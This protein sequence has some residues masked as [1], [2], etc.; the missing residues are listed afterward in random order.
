MFEK[1]VEIKHDTDLETG[2]ITCG[3]G[4]GLDRMGCLFKLSKTIV[5]SRHHEYE[6]PDKCPGVGKYRMTLEKIDNEG[7]K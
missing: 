7:V 1:I 2:E 6:K 3:R 4:C 5:V